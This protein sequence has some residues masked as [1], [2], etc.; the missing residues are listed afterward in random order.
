MWTS[1]KSINREQPQIRIHLNLEAKG[2]DDLRLLIGNFRA[3]TSESTTF[4]EVWED[5]T[6]LLGIAALLL[7]VNKIGDLNNRKKSST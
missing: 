1:S 5:R 4:S 3:L 6:R 7:L 2:S